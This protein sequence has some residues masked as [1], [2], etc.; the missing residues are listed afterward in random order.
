MSAEPSTTENPFLTG[1]MAPVDDERNDTDLEVVGEL[2]DAL[3]GM[4]TRNG[5]NPQYPP[6]D[7]YH[8]FDGDGMVHTVYFEGGKARYRNRYIESAG[9]LAE[10]K[11]GR[12][13]FG[14]ISKFR[15]PE[16]DVL[17]EVGGMK[18]NAN[19]HFVRHANRYL[20]L[21]EAG[22]PTELSRELETIG[23]YDFGGKLKGP[24]TAHPKIDPKTGEMLF[25][26]YSPIP[27]YLQYHVAD[28]DGKLVHS[29]EIDLE[30]P[31]MMHDF[32]VT[33]NYALFVDAP[34]V[35]DVAAMMNGQPGIRWEP[36]RGT[37][38]GVLPRRGT[39]K[40]IRW[41]DISSAYVV[42]FFN[43]F[44]DG[45]MVEIY[46]PAFDEMP[47]GLQFDNPVQTQEPIPTHWS[48]DM[49]SGT[50]KHEQFDDRSGEFPRINDDYAA[51]KNRF[52][53]NSRARDWE[54]GFN[55]NG[56]IKYDMESGKTQ[57]FYY[58]DSQV[59][60]E[61][62]FAPDPGGKAE[63][64]GWLMTVV[65]DRGTEQSEL[66]ILDARALADGPVA[67]IQMPRRVPIGFH[68]NWLPDGS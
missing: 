49:A 3:R 30:T 4:F 59:S 36:E 10:R 20:A 66:V 29:V 47:G 51:H 61:H 1:L 27:P 9:L 39:Q 14:S 2:P 45:N 67:R 25:F 28:A 53:Y 17:A 65:S 58:D 55:F 54:F 50:V 6:T 44:D 15:M 5:P 13:C 12:S 64:D 32:A 22:P 57:E 43:A 52:M 37:R 23:V 11:R 8:P 19:T 63:D 34:A 56:V 16:P 46:G 31:V 40:D 60:G 68:A 21:M 26:G 38:I 35:F 62:V 41:F 24:M 33:E 42:H 7:A 48:I 18:N